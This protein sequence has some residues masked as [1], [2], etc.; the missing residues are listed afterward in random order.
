MAKRALKKKNPAA[1]RRPSAGRA[2]WAVFLTALLVRLVY[3]CEG[4]DNPAFI[5]PIVDSQTYDGLARGIASGLPVTE[6]LFW[7]PV[8]YPLFLS[9][10]YRLSHFSILFVKIVQSLLGALTALL[11]FRLGDKIFGRTAGLAAGI[12][13]AFYMPLVFFETELLAA[14]WAALWL[15]AM[16]LV[17]LKIREKPEP[18]RCFFFGLLGALAVVTRPVF[19]LF[20]AASCAWLAVAWIREHSRTANLT[21]RAVSLAAGFLAV[22]IPVAVLSH[23]ATGRVR[24]FPYSGGVNLYIGN[25]PDYE[26]TIAIRPGL[27]WRELTAAPA[28]RGIETNPGMERYFLDR[29]KSYALEEP[30]GFMTGLARKTARFFSSR[31][32]PRNTDIYLFRKWSLM[33]RVLVWKT[34]G[35]GFPFGALLPLVFLGLIFY[36]KPLSAPLLLCLVFYPVSVIAVFAAARYRVPLIPVLSVLAGAGLIVLWNVFRKKQWKKLAAAGAVVFFAAAAGS[37]PGPFCEEKLD[38]EAELYFGL[39]STFEA[40]GEQGKAVSAYKRAIGFKADYAEAHF[41]LA[42]ILMDRGRIEEAVVHYRESVKAAPGSVEVRNNF[43]AALRAQGKIPEA[44]VQWEKTLGINPGDAF[45]HF[46]IGAVSAGRGDYAR[47]AEHFKQALSVRPE[48]AEAHMRL[49]ISL[50]YL[51]EAGKAVT[52][53]SEAVRIRPDDADARCNLGIALGRIGKYDEAVVQLREA[54]RL[55][56]DHIAARYNLGYA[57][58]LQKKYAEAVEQY[59]R[60]LQTDPSHAGSLLRLAEAEAALAGERE[61]R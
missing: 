9:L 10:L 58:H 7:Q 25:N 4:S 53:F 44:V 21:G 51:G 56:P 52:H 37:I 18:R 30:G 20:F 41:N 27:G 26:K 39:G 59:R 54:V 33:L 55:E 49:G 29:A 23:Q 11:S 36:R 45:A 31:E 2:A 35:F 50:S 8:F 46:N 34:G 5:R 12:I 6:E 43:A 28:R 38:Y 14:G 19:A 1:T 32:I 3:L 40:L 13:A 47:S 61:N 48:W 57:L 42:N 60:V 24:L 17:L 22:A 15:T 16:V